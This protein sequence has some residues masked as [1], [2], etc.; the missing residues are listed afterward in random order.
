MPGSLM[1]LVIDI[2]GGCEPPAATRCDMSHIASP[3]PAQVPVYLPS[4]DERLEAIAKSIDAV[5]SM[6]D[7]VKAAL[8]DKA[9]E[10]FRYRR[11]HGFASWAKDRLGISRSEVYRLLRNHARFGCGS[12]SVP[13][14]DTLAPALPRAAID[15]LAD[16]STPDEV[17]QEVGARVTA[18][19]KWLSRTT[20]AGL[21][22]HAKAKA[23]GLS[24]PGDIAAANA[25]DPTDTGSA[26]DNDVTDDGDDAEAPGVKERREQHAAKFGDPESPEVNGA[27]HEADEHH[28]A[29]VPAPMSRAQ[30][31]ASLIWHQ[32]FWLVEL[33]DDGPEHF[34]AVLDHLLGDEDV[35]D[36]LVQLARNPNVKAVIAAVI[37]KINHD[38]CSIPAFLD[39]RPSLAS[40]EAANA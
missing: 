4:F 38:D 37:A 28:N 9:H 30:K 1:S 15:L 25:G 22:E 10:L 6:A 33:F 2:A 17:C 34:N 11:D 14:W 21:I 31:H 12:E 8:L 26:A 19:E 20:V 16:P 39:R 23:A 7:S 13:S 32:L 3:P 36:A 5:Q 40:N 35:I 29:D 27:G 24:E 18:G